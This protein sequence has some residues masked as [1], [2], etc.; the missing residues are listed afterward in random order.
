V[1]IAQYADEGALIAS[2]IKAGE[3]IVS[4]GVHKIVA[5][6]KIHALD[7]GSAQ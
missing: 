1:Q 7:N 3:R 5:G 4:A 2:G 6:E